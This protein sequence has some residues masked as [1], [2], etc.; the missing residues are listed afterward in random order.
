MLISTPSLLGAD[1]SISYCSSFAPA[2]FIHHRGTQKTLN[3][4]THIQTV[5]KHTIISESLKMLKMFKIN[6][7][8]SCH[9]NFYR[10]NH[11]MFHADKF[12]IH[13]WGGL[14]SKHL[15]LILL[16]LSNR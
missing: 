7:F 1:F 2:C 5:Y 15:Y 13:V 16:S 6:E 11:P 8:L 9:Y 14:E 4:Y 12:K 3:M 10:S